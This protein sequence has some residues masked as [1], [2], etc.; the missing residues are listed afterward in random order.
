[1]PDTQFDYLLGANFIAAFSVKVFFHKDSAELGCVK[2]VSNGRVPAYQTVPIYF[3]GQ[4]LKLQVK[5]PR[6]FK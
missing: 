4:T 6:L 2:G 1:M 3:K 5:G